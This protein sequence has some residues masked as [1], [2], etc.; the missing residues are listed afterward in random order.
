MQESMTKM[1]A[2]LHYH[3]PSSFHPIWLYRQGYEGKNILKEITDSCIRNQIDICAIV[4]R[5]S[6]L[7]VKKGSA[8]DR[9][10]YLLRESKQLPEGYL[11]VQLGNNVLTVK[12]AGKS[13]YIINSQSVFAQD[14][15]RVV[16]HIVLGSN[17]VKNKQPLGKT[18]RNI[19]FNSNLINIAEHPF[20]LD[21][22]GVGKDGLDRYLDY[23]DAIEGHNSQFVL[24]RFW[25][26]LPIIG[27]Y[28]KRVNE[29]AREYAK[30]ME[31]P[32]IA[33]SDGHRIEDVGMSHI[34]LEGISTES[35]ELLL[36]TLKEAIREN[37]FTP[38]C[39]YPNMKDWLCWAV[40]SKLKI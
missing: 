3:G 15:G 12:R 28:T 32:W 2:D 1:N 16:E 39:R 25:G 18:L 29:K 19:S 8:D 37:R 11:P 31:K 38:V 21:H 40:R 14:S 5:S 30:Q 26:D 9:F 35:E 33:T 20:S 22:G 27:D 17:E 34:E 13:I 36:R 4:S 23:Y 24:P 6:S 10:G 7:Q